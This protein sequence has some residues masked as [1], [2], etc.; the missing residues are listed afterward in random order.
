M[1][2]M[3]ARCWSIWVAALVLVGPASRTR[4]NCALARAQRVYEDSRAAHDAITMDLFNGRPVEG[5]PLSKDG[6]NHAVWRVRLHND[7]TG[8]DRWAIFK[9]RS[10]GDEDGWARAPMEYV[11]YH[12][13]HHYLLMDYIP[14]VAYRRDIDVRGHHFAEGAMIYEVPEFTVLYDT[15]D[16][17]WG[18]TPEVVTADHRVLAVIG[19]N[20]D[21]HYKNLGR[22]RH[23]VDG[24]T[25][26]VFIDWGASFRPGTNVS[27]TD[28]PAYRNSAPVT[29]VS[30]RTYEALRRVSFDAGAWASMKRDY[31]SFMSDWEIGEM[32]RAAQG[33]RGYFDQLI[34]QRGADQVLLRNRGD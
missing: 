7:A 8:R 20:Q 18:E 27:M 34:Q 11:M 2:T 16:D 4:A 17:T 22:G 3:T 28:Y 31:G 23:W 10:H 30:R 25:R 13:G 6:N 9:P 26:P 12:F 29:R 33:I 24:T 5:G 32:I 19:K 21:G 14:P 15:P 1:R